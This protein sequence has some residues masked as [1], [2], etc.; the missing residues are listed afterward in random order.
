MGKPAFIN[1]NDIF[2]KRKRSPWRNIECQRDVDYA[3][4]DFSKG[5]LVCQQQKKIDQ[6]FTSQNR[7][8][9]IKTQ[10]I[11]PLNSLGK[12]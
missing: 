8:D 12:W 10:S 2:R 1:S 11:E 7:F 9:S 6:N 4:T 3:F 5:K